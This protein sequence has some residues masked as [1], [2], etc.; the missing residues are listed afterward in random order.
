[1]STIRVE[2]KVLKYFI[3][4]SVFGDCA[5]EKTIVDLQEEGIIEALVSI[6]WT[7]PTIKQYCADC[8][9]WTE[10]EP[11]NEKCVPVLRVCS[12][13]GQFTAA[14]GPK[15]KEQEKRQCSDC[16]EY[17]R[18]EARCPVKGATV[19]FDSEPCGV[20]AFDAAEDG[21]QECSERCQVKV[22]TEEDKYVSNDK[23]VLL[24]NCIYWH[25]DHPLR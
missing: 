18:L 23:H 21:A 19:G 25:R 12:V 6:G 16:K 14:V 3:E 15:N 10:T 1:M 11:Y 13:C 17:G 2:T 24:S 7:P 20:V 22:E 5:T 4:Q 9:Q 8:K